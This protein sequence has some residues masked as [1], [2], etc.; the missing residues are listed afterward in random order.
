MEW[1]IARSRLVEVHARLFGGFAEFLVLLD[2]V[3]GNS[4]AMMISR[5]DVE[6]RR[7]LRP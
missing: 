2:F 3:D 7:G 1:C 6:C 4:G 5:F